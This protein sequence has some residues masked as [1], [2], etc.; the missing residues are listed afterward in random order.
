MPKGEAGVV[1]WGGGSWKCQ[2]EHGCGGKLVNERHKGEV[3]DQ[4]GRIQQW[5]NEGVSTKQS[6]ALGSALASWLWMYC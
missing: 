4:W 6:M 2:P 5:M 1:F 3:Y